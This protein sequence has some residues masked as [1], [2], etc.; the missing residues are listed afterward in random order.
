V[1]TLKQNFEWIFDGDAVDGIPER[2]SAIEV[3]FNFEEAAKDYASGGE[4]EPEID[5]TET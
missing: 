4:L 3:F 5:A 2:V 1:Q